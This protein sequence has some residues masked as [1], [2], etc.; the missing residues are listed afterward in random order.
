MA[1]VWGPNYVTPRAGSG[2]IGNGVLVCSNSKYN[3]ALVTLGISV[4]DS[5]LTHDVK[6]KL[7][8]E[9]TGGAFWT[10]AQL[11]DAYKQSDG[12]HYPPWGGLDNRMVDEY[13]Y[14]IGD[15][16][17]YFG[18][19]TD[20]QKASALED[21]NAILD[22]EDIGGGGSGGDVD[23]YIGFSCP[24]VFTSSQYYYWR[25][26]KGGVTYTNNLIDAANGNYTL[27]PDT[28][29]VY[30]PYDSISGVSGYES[31]LQKPYR[32]LIM[33]TNSTHTNSL[34][35]SYM[36]F[37]DVPATTENRTFD[38]NYGGVSKSGTYVSSISFA[39]NVDT[40]GRSSSNNQ[41]P[42]S[43]FDF[44][45]TSFWVSD[46]YN[47]GAKGAGTLYS[48]T[49]IS[50]DS[51]TG[52]N[53][54]GTPESNWPETPEPTTPTAP[55][56][57]AP[58]N[59]QI[60]ISSRPT[61]N[62]VWAPQTTTTTT[63]TIYD[64]SQELRSIYDELVAF[65]LDSTTAYNSM[66]GGLNTVS[67]GI[68]S[69]GTD[70][71]NQF[72]WL[73][74]NLHAVIDGNFLALKQYLRQLFEWL[75]SQMDFT[76]T[77]GG[78]NDATVVSWLKRI[79]SR[80][81]SGINTRPNDPVANPGESVDWLGQ[82]IET[83]LGGLGDVVSSLAADVLGLVDDVH[84]KF[85]FSIPW[86]ALAAFTSLAAVP[87]TPHFTFDYVI[88]GSHVVYDIDL[89]PYNDLAALARSVFIYFWGFLLLMKTTWLLDILGGATNMI[90]NFAVQALGG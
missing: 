34:P 84:D 8:N 42:V 37:S 87:T 57:P 88:A 19:Y 10:F 11:F 1:V 7:S 21:L 74:D 35:L 13:A 62:F 41:I 58:G 44:D 38:A 52:G 86:D 66:I 60:T 68:T 15:E 79:W 59:V 22:G 85:P 5:R 39:S 36:V 46:T 56:V 25:F 48:G 30:I 77:G 76:V 47:F 17:L 32:Y 28:V 75:A 33:H 12:L 27:L 20:A 9:S 6:A 43:S 89:A 14:L 70:M 55:V 16:W 53:G 80:L 26:S 82:F 29:N 3:A 45:G 24:V 72:S 81:G 69:L 2:V 65:H 50:G 63:T 51:A 78:Y 23:G 18:A 61:F 83:L 4:T 71:D 31:L 90:G 49:P 67:Q 40:I 54:G 64:N 73:F